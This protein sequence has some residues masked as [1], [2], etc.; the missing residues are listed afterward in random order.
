MPLNWKEAVKNPDSRY[1]GMPFWSWNGK[2]DPA[3]IE[4]QIEEFHSMKLGGFF[5]HSR[6]GLETPYLSREWFD[7]VRTAVRKAAELNLHACLYDEDRWASGTAGGLV[8]CHEE[9]RGQFLYL[10]LFHDRTAYK[11]HP[12]ELGLWAAKLSGS[13]ADGL[14]RIISPEQAEHGETLIEAF[15]EKQS[16]EP[17]YNNTSYLDVLNPEA[18]RSFLHTTHQRYL[19]ELGPDFGTTAPM[20]FT[21][22]PHCLR[23]CAEQLFPMP[24]PDV[25]VCAWN[26]R[27]PERFRELCGFPLTEHLPEL[28]F[29]SDLHD[30]GMVRYF[31]FKALTE[32]FVSSYTKQISEWCGKHGIQLTGHLLWEDTP[33]SQSRA[34]GAVMRHYSLMQIPGMDQLTEYAQLYG[35]CKQLASAARQTGRQYRISEVYGC[36][37][38][39]TSLAACKAMADWQYVLGVNQRCLH[40][41]HYTLKGEAKRDYPASFS[42]HSN[43]ASAMPLLEDYFARLGVILSEGQEIRDLLVLHPLES[44]W[45]L[46]DSG[47]Q[48]ATEFDRKLETLCN[49]L[50]ADAIDFDYGDEEMLSVSGSV[51]NQNGTPVLRIGKAVYRAVLLPEA[52]TIRR[53]TLDLLSGFLAAGGIAARLGT[54]PERVDGVLCPDAHMLYDR[55]PYGISAVEPIVRRVRFHSG[56]QQEAVSLLYQL[57]ELEDGLSLTICNTGLNIRNGLH[58]RV[59]ERRIEYPDLTVEIATEITGQWYELEPESGKLHLQEAEK[60]AG[61]YR[62][63]TSFLPLQ[64]RIFILG[65]PGEGT[66]RK[67]KFYCSKIF[68]NSNK[69]PVRLNLPNSLVLDHPEWEFSGHKGKTFILHLDDL[70]RRKLG[71]PVR[72]GNMLQPWANRKSEDRKLFLTLNYE[73]E[74]GEMPENSLHLCLEDPEQWNITLN[75]VPVPDTD[76]GEWIDHAIRKRE[77]PLSLLKPGPNRITL[78]GNYHT[79]GSGLEAVYLTGEFGISKNRLI[80]PVTELAPGDWCG[81]GLPNYAGDVRYCFEFESGG[82]DAV[83]R[84]ENV[85]AA[86]LRIFLNGKL[87]TILGWEPFETELPDLRPG[88]NELEIEIIGSRRN[89]LGPFFLPD[90]HPSRFGAAAFREHEHPERRDL[91][92]YGLYSPPEIIYY[93]TETSKEKTGKRSSMLP[94]HL[95]K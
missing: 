50:L 70:I 88:H 39:D 53:T 25:H 38:W 42:K 2:M 84:L 65:K 79:S 26:S 18:V 1:R 90:P 69:I 81:Q 89:L 74:I 9:F 52:A 58:T 12:G 10:R 37:G 56:T 62:I 92:P 91:T 48:N 55:L 16:P 41:S 63:P 20:I 51:E 22:E 83:L 23:Y 67:T 8:T 61:G 80:H 29:S 7:C 30:S 24:Y 32:L 15:V 14:H 75:G 33:A 93:T 34:G 17:R 85:Q 78:T 43:F 21:D 71:V 95:N 76:C 11:Q 19:D 31:Y 73:F 46:L 64:T 68:L 28:F 35:T 36:T 60:T 4:Q 59:S 77:L 13:R 54:A 47:L 86:A 57:R 40:L 27:I 49:E 5:M 6:M 82:G 72:T 44:A 3:R 94:E 87:Q 66:L 45:I